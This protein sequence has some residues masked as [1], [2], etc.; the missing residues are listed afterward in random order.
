MLA[1]QSITEIDS[2][3]HANLDTLIE[4]FFDFVAALVLLIIAL[5]SCLHTVLRIMFAVL[6]LVLWALALLIVFLYWLRS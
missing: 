2:T 5:C 3:L 1:S 4:G 6:G